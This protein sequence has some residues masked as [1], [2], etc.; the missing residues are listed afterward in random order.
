MPFSDARRLVL[1]TTVAALTVAACS[2]TASTPE[3][4]PVFVIAGQSNAKGG[5]PLSGLNA[6]AAVLPVDDQPL[7]LDERAAARSAFQAGIGAMCEAD[8]LT[9]SVLADASIDAL[10]DGGL[11][12]GG[13][14]ERFE[15]SG[16]EIVAHR[17]QWALPN[18][19]LVDISNED[20]AGAPEWQRDDPTP[21]AGGFG[22]ISD[23]AMFY[24][25]ELGFGLE[26][27]R[28]VQKFGVVK[29]TMSGSALFE[30]WAPGAQLRQALFDRTE[31]YLADRP[32]H[33]VAAFI[34]F[35][36][37]NDQF[38]EF[39]IRDYD[40][41]LNSLVS[42]VRAEHGAETPVI[43]VES[44]RPDDLPTLGEIADAQQRVVAGLS[45]A[46]LVSTSGL[47]TCFHYDSTSQ[48]VIG[49]RIARA[50]RDLQATT[51]QS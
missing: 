32:D 22:F 29:V 34:W 19:S 1:A 2:S 26:L 25:P 8:D 30:Q 16:A 42:E 27:E 33:E 48:L 21:L 36:G 15:I 6:L 23:E 17:Y 24:G 9:P 5:A 38:E 46:A 12:I 20:D 18:E 49:Q 39:S 31:E 44:R 43:V 11:D 41:N 37:F 13:I 51:S 47:T 50:W 45:N 7:S 14:D 4:I 28:D 10:R 40:D 35:Q 3:S